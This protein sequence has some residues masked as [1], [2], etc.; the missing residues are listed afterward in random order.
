MAE[1]LVQH[2]HQRQGLGAEP[3]IAMQQLVQPAAFNAVEIGG[4]LGL[5]T[6]HLAAFVRALNG[7]VV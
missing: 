3:G 7:A 6:E 5:Q 2:L 4:L 1:L